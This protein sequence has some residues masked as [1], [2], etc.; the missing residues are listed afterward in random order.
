MKKYMIRCDMEGA[1][2]IVSYEQAEPGKSEYEEGRGYFMSD[3]LA[4]IEGLQLGGADEIHVYDEHYYGRNIDLSALPQGVVAYCG[5]PPYRADWA[6]GLNESFSGFILLGLHSKRG[7]EGALLNHTYE[8]DLR[9]I[10]INGRSVGEIG[11][12]AAIAGDCGVPFQLIVGDS[13][14]VKEARSLVAGVHGVIVKESHS[15]YGALCYPLEVTRARIREAAAD[16][17]RRPPSAAPFKIRGPVTLEPVFFDTQFARKYREEYGSAVLEGDS[18][19]AC[20][21]EYLARKR[22]VQALIIS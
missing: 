22:T 2:G 8:P 9:D 16:I 18:V 7:T 4:L 3:L 13:E 6:G 21:A 1:S 19:L 17:V 15:E 14:G 11:V 20:W 10:R 5:K 12:E